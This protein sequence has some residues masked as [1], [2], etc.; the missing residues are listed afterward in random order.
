MS[1]GIMGG[2]MIGMILVAIALFF[3]VAAVFR[4]LWN[5]TIPD[6]FG[7]KEITY[8]QGFRMMI[9]ALILFGG[10]VRG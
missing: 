5:I 4:W 6:V 3:V 8:W 10:I 2:M 7:I 1:M 9:L